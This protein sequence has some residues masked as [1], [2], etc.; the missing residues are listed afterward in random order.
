VIYDGMPYD[1][2]QGQD[3][4]HSSLK[5]VKIVNFEACLLR[6]YECSQKTDG[7]L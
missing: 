5:S 7:E 3:Q 6:Q 1:P 4:G 2:I